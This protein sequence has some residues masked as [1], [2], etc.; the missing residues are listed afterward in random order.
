M[1]D[2]KKVVRIAI[3]RNGHAL[4]DS[5]YAYITV[6]AVHYDGSTESLGDHHDHV[7]IGDLVNI[8]ITPKGWIQICLWQD[9]KDFD[10]RQAQTEKGISSCIVQVKGGSP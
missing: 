3:K 10:V 9:G 2:P 4:H 6:H 5:G 1:T 7:L 8:D